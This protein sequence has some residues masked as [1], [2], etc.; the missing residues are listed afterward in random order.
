MKY[1][2]TSIIDRKGKDALAVD[3]LG[4]IPG[5]APDLPE[6]GFAPIPMWIADMNFPV[7]PNIQKS[8]EERIQHPAFGYFMV[9][10]EYYQSIINWQ[11][12]RNHLT[13]IKKEEIGYENGVLGGLMSAIRA[14]AQ[15]GDSILLHS[16]TYIGFT[17][18]IEEGGYHIVNTGL[19]LDK[20]HVWRMDYEDMDQKLKQYKIHVA[21]F[22]NPHNPTG[23]VWEKEELEKA[24]EIYKKNDCIVISDEIWSDILLNG[25]Q[26]TPLLSVNEDA[27]N[28]TIA[29]YAPSK[30]FNLA[31]LIGSY[32]IICNK[33]LRDRVETSGRKSHYNSMNVL[34]MHALIG[35]YN[36]DGEQW[37]DELCQTLSK[38]INYAY[39]HI[40]KNYKGIRLSK[41]QGTYML[42]L[43]C[44][45]WCEENKKEIGWLLKEGWKVGVEWQ[46]GRKFHGEYS[47][48]INTA[49]PF[50]KIEEAFR[51]LDQYVFHVS[52]KSY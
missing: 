30:T 39:D 31:G 2:F 13:G 38:N 43:D 18:T 44:R 29:L 12:R 24:M 27:R 36:P 21:V 32:H 49:L 16:P 9:P 11:E 26:Y 37:V 25:N 34:S 15:P 5:F 20:D 52:G 22:C 1:D 4:K 35:A 3:G 48:R 46:D 8:M 41:P 7:L 28:R 45:Q 47:I 40:M 51:R 50:S 14:F 23:R 42:F 17:S 10:D 19:I 33:Y 6:E